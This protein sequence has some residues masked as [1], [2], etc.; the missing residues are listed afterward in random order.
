MIR[1]WLI[2]CQLILTARAKHQKPDHQK[3]ECQADSHF[4]H[5]SPDFSVLANAAMTFQRPIMLL[6]LRLAESHNPRGMIGRSRKIIKHLPCSQATDAEA[7]SGLP[8][9][10]ANKYLPVWSLCRRRLQNPLNRVF[11]N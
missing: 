10:T 8:S 5:K 11:P 2:G 4:F 9:A 3:E 1:L 7:T 6:L